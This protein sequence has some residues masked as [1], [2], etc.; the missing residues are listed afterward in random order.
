MFIIGQLNLPNIT[1]LREPNNIKN[2]TMRLNIQ[3]IYEYQKID[4]DR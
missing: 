3:Y 4:K 1:K 2:Q